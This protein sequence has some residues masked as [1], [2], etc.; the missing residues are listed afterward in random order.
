MRS[1]L[2]DAGRKIDSLARR[3]W[4]LAIWHVYRRLHLKYAEHYRTRLNGVGFVG[5]TGSAGKTTAKSMVV[6]ILKRAGKVKHFGGAGNRIHHIAQAICATRP[7]DGYCVLELGAEH[8][9]FFDR[10]V[11]LVRPTIGVVTTVGEDHYNAFRSREAIAAEK[12]KLIAA[13]SPRGTAVLNADDPL[14]WGMRARFG[15]RVV[16]FGVGDGADVRARDI[17]SHWPERLTFTVSYAGEDYAVRT[18]FCGIH[19]VTSTLAAL[20]TGVAAGVPL[21]T[22]VAAICEVAPPKARMEPVTTPDGITFIRDDWKAPYWGM[23]TVFDFLRDAKAARKVLVIG[24]LSDYEGS[25]RIKYQRIGRKALEVA[26]VVMFVGSQ[27]TLGLRAQ[28]HAAQGHSLMAFPDIREAAAALQGLL[29]SGDLVVLKGSGISDHL[30]RLY[31]VRTGPVACWRK[32]CGKMTLCDGCR[33]LRPARGETEPVL[34]V[35]P[36]PEAPECEVPAAPA[37]RP[38]RVLVG[39]GNTGEKYRNTPHNVGFAVLDLLAERHGLRWESVDQAEIARLERDGA[40][41]LL[42]KPQGQVNNTGKSM[43]ELSRAMG[44]A[45]ADCILVHDDLHLPA[46]VLRTRMKGSDG[47]HLGVRS[48]VVTFQS[49]EIP[50]VKIGVAAAANQVPTADY[51]VSPMPAVVSSKVQEGCNAAVERLLKLAGIE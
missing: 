22:A 27:A 26:D 45:A 17:R 7:E 21:A 20:A 42:V 1:R 30:G 38:L 50:R 51:L 44:F 12:G 19:W 46:G 35:L 47:G 16:S 43:L 25:A 39:I 41:I 31:H 10:M 5:I 28:K 32:S 49:G 37:G 9:G 29:R 6:A 40:D 8:P 4:S 3:I 36:P 18:Q 13:L 15:G 23:Q 48:M 11:R 2:A 14:V 34:A 33:L 24:T